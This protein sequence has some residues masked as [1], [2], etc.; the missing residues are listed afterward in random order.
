MNLTHF[1]NTW[2]TTDF[3]KDDELTSFTGLTPVERAGGEDRK[4]GFAEA[5]VRPKT[6]APDLGNVRMIHRETSN[7]TGIEKLLKYAIYTLL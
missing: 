2:K 7:T 4:W 6:T 3:G 1:H 5:F